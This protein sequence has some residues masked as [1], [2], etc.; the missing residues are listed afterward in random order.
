M[1]RVI[2]PGLDV[3]PKTVH[4]VVPG[5]TGMAVDEVT[6]EERVMAVGMDE[7]ALYT[8]IESFNIRMA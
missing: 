6:I 4:A 2:G 3:S 7:A 8:E 1:P 5:G